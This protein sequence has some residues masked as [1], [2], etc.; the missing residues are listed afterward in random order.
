MK[1]K[2]LLEKLLKTNKDHKVAAALCG[3]LYDDS[4]DMKINVIG[5]MHSSGWL[6]NRIKP[7][8]DEFGHGSDTWINTALS[9]AIASDFDDYAVC[10]LL[11]CNPNLVIKSAINLGLKVIAI[12][13]IDPGILTLNFARSLMLPNIVSNVVSIS[14]AVKSTILSDVAAMKAI[15]ADDEFEFLSG[16]ISGRCNAS[17]YRRATLPYGF[18]NLPSSEIFDIKPKLISTLDKELQSSLIFFDK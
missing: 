18:W 17:Y 3:V 1:N 4:V 12:E 15:I 9:R 2:K 7:F 13:K 11:N 14:W 8:L 10:A 6:P 16:Q 5:A